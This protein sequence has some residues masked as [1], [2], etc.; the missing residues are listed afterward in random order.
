MATA[1]D[2]ALYR[3]LG[4]RLLGGQPV[5]VNQYSK[6]HMAVLARFT[7]DGGAYSN[8]STKLLVLKKNLLIGNPLI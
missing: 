2:H 5:F 8:A 6:D 4:V 7:V 3:G 1:T